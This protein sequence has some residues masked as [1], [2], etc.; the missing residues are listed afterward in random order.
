VDR[1]LQALAASLHAKEIVR[2][3][4]RH[5]G[6]RHVV[7][8][9]GRYVGDA[10]AYAATRSRPLVDLL[11]AA[12]MLPSIYRIDAVRSEDAAYTNKPGRAYRVSLTSGQ[13]AREALIDDRPGARR[14]TRSSCA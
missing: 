6:R 14:V 10:G 11:C 2:A 8:M 1:S 13:T 4:D 3:V 12:V 5:E 7:A 9:K